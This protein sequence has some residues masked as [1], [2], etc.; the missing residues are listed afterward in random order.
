MC[1]RDLLYAF[2][3]QYM[4]AKKGILFSQTLGT[5]AHTHSLYV[6]THI[7]QIKWVHFTVQ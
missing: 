7:A 3:P 1:Y 2:Q 4:Q 5:D 6:S